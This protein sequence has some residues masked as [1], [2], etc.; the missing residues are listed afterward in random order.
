MITVLAYVPIILSLLL[1]CAHFFRSGDMLLLAAVAALV[2]ALAIRKAWLARTVQFALVFGVFE[3]L[4]TGMILAAERV[5]AGVPYQ[6]MLWILGAVAAVTLIS[7]L[8]F[9]TRTLGNIYGLR[10]SH[11]YQ[12]DAA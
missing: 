11:R 1:L 5:H 4:R 9:Q 8:L 12:G 7:A 10:H 6:R 2:P 3:W